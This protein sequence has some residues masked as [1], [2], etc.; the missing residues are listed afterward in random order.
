MIFFAETLGVDAEILR[1]VIESNNR[2]RSDRD[3]EAMKGRAVSE[4]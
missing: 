3:W 1:S 4:N 2:I